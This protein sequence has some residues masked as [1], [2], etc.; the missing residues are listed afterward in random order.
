MEYLKKYREEHPEGT[1]VRHG[2]TCRHFRKRYSDLR[3][4]EGKALRSV[5]DALVED[6]GGES[7]LTVGQ[8]LVL[9]RLK[10]K[11]ISLALIDQWIDRQVEL[12]TSGGDVAPVMRNAHLAYSDS[13]RKDVEALYNLT[14]K[15]PVKVVSL[16]DY[17]EGKR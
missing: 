12:I 16:D 8:K 4:R 1:N 13:L 10:A 7:E 2:S 3:T 9:G 11:M 17:I 5:L 15:R 14:G 6:L